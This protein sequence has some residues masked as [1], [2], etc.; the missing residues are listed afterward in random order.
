MKTAPYQIQDDHSEDDS[1]LYRNNRSE[2][3][4][5]PIGDSDEGV[6]EE[7]YEDE[8]VHQHMIASKD[9]TTDQQTRVKV[10]IKQ[11]ESIE[12]EDKQ[13]NEPK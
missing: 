8:V 12:E 3:I 13:D 4:S 6:D 2:S 10:E 7:K 11:S 5:K 1:P 9:N